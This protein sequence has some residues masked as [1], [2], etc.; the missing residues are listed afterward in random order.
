M[1]AIDLASVT[2]F[3]LESYP[4]P[5]RSDGRESMISDQTFNLFLLKI[6]FSF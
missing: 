6:L 3:L 4:S 2:T 1:Q 5:T